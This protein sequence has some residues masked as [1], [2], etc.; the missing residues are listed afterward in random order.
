MGYWNTKVLPKI[1]K[2]F[3]TN[4]VKKAAAADA[5]KAFDESKE[6]Y[7][8]EFEE[9]KTELEPKVLVI[10]E[11]A[12]V[13]LKTLIKEKKPSGLK[14]QS[15]VVQKFLEELSGIEFPGSK[16][17]HE[18]CTKVG[19]GLLPGPIFFV[20]EKVS[21][22]IPVEVEK[23][24]EA[25]PAEPE[26]E[27]KPTEGETSTVKEEIVVEEEKKEEVKVEAEVE[28]V[29]PPPKA[30]ETTPAEPPKTS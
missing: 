5:C 22:F 23:K 7:T 1:K 25:T 10:Y 12:S 21:T 28:K 6:S 16:P 18:A 4:S 24:E 20:F 26:A 27:S 3:E 13:E 19:P 29:E 15:V 8:T 2:V 14:K 30:E 9:K 17:V 11:A